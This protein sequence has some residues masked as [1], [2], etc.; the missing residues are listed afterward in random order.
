V[1]ER[2]PEGGGI[3]L[4]RDRLWWLEASGSKANVTA[5]KMVS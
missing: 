5:C 1:L 4:H 3:A 2:R